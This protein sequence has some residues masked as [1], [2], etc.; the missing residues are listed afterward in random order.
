MRDDRNDA[1][2]RGRE[3]DRLVVPTT[4][5][6]ETRHA[7]GRGRLEGS[8]DAK[9]KPWTQGRV[10]LPPNLVR[11][12]DAATRDK[13]ARF[14]A[15][16]HHVDGEA[17]NRAF[18]RLRRNAAAGVDGETVE[19]YEQGLAER[20]RD[21]HDQVHGGRYR[22]HPVRRVY[23]PKS[24]GGQRPLGIPALEDKIVQGA[25]A[26]VL[27]AVYEVDFL[28]FSYGFRPGRSPHLALRALHTALMTQYVN[29]VLDADIRSFFDSVDHGWLLRMLAHRI[30]DRR[31]LTLIRRWLQ[32]GILETNEWRATT[33]GTPQGA[34]ISP[35][36][37][38][39]F[40][41]YVLDLWAQQWRRRHAR[42]RVVIVRY[43]DDFVMGFQYE[44]DARRMQSDLRER[45]AKFQLRLHQ[46]KTRLIE[47]GRL[48]AEQR[49]RRGERRPRTF[50]FLGFT[51]YCAWSRTG[52]F[53]VK[54]RTERKRLTRKLHHVR[55][56]LRRRMHAP[57]SSQQA[58]L[59]SVL[60]GHYLYY[61]LPSNWHPLAGFRQ[62]VRRSWYNVLRR[63]SQ[64]RLTW[65]GFN[66]LLTRFPL[67]APHLTH[68]RAA[69]A[70]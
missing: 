30:A 50:A 51:H 62:E 38:N 59:S 15:V 63:R 2:S 14:T 22:P 39:I 6:K 23:I 10:S 54:R 16:L 27:S 60:R 46:E 57:I 66:A 8:L 1:L 69:L 55:D 24:D 17:L 21:L 12:N 65:K 36:L 67:P 5:P 41:H 53:V 56:E 61:G 49:R 48:A 68:S 26:E 43:A 42:G 34:G 35:L 45:L 44:A 40:L 4:L 3:S 20:L 13:S 28:G 70:V 25:V 33:E 32:A 64:R 9:A 52:A 7:E 31:I 37:A 18:R 11:V 19:T 29:W 58:W 47:F